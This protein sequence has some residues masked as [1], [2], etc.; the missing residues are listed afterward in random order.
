[1]QNMM[2]CRAAKVYFRVLSMMSFRPVPLT[3]SIVLLSWQ[4]AWKREIHRS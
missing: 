2:E 1:M 4:M 3:I